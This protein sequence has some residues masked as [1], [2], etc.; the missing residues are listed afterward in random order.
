LFGRFFGCRRAALSKPQLRFEITYAIPFSRP[1]CR[2]SRPQLQHER[3]Q[4][5][6][7]SICKRKQ[8]LRSRRFRLGK[9]KPVT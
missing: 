1:E 8:I 4:F 6:H 3:F 9:I 5:L 7:T 2:S